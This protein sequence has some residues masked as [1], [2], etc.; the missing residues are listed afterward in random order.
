MRV[1]MATEISGGE[2]TV[3]RNWPCVVLWLLVVVVGFTIFVMAPMQG[4]RWSALV[5]SLV[6]TWLLYLEAQGIIIETEALSFPVRPFSWFP[7]F[8]I[9]RLSVPLS[10]IERIVIVSISVRRNGGHIDERLFREAPA[11]NIP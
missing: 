5:L 6:S 1:E 8:T 10:N 2:G 9:T 3:I 11:T 4:A 7:L